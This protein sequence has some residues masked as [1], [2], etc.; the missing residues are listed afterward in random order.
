[1]PID[2]AFSVMDQL[3]AETIK[4]I[5]DTITI[6]SLVNIDFADVKAIMGHGGVAVMLVGEAK[7]QDKANA[8][9]RDCLSHRCWT[10]TTGEPL[11][12]LCTSLEG[13]TSR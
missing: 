3:I 9:V 1:M 4:G 6:P 12:H 8:V 2:A 7:A 10:L 13:M 11:V 5:S